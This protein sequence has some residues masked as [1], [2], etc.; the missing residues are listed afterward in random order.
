MEILDKFSDPNLIGTMTVGEKIT[1]TMITTILGMGITFLSLILI[2][3]MII[4]MSKI[5]NPEKKKE[6][7]K[8]V[9]APSQPEV[10]E[11]DAPVVDEG[12]SG[13]VI[14]VIAASIAASL[15]TSIHNIVV[16]NV[17]RVSEASP[18]WNSAGRQEQMN[19]RF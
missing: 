11:N 1:A 5:L 3:G 7:I 8:V 15:N 6:V 19:T 4:V 17:V 10:V 13:E 12:I 14:A 18:A 2:W 16:R 9:N